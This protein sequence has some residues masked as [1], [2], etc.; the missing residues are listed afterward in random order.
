MSL[1]SLDTWV[2][3]LLPQ[4]ERLIQSNRL[5]A[6]LHAMPTG[7]VILDSQG[8]IVDA[9]GNA[10][11]LLGEPLVAL[12]WIKVIERS[13]SPKE[14]DGHEVSLK[15]GRRVKISL[16]PLDNKMGELIV[17]TDLTE[18]RHLQQKIAHLQRLSALGE[19]IATLAHQIRTPLSA[20]LLYASHLANQKLKVSDKKK[21][22][23][24]LMQRLN[25]LEVQV[26]DLLAFAQDQRL[27]LES[28]CLADVIEMSVEV[29]Q[30]MLKR[31]GIEIQVEMSTLSEVLGHA[32]ALSSVLN[33]L[34]MNAI[35]AKASKIKVNLSSEDKTFVL[36]IED[37]GCGF[38]QKLTEQVV[39]PF[40]TSKSYGTG[41]GL[42]VV[43]K[44]M[45]HHGGEL[46]LSSELEQGCQV[47]LNFPKICGEGDSNEASHSHC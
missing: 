19:M 9:N 36:S 18:T 7:V 10:A 22:Q 41:L 40:Y 15:D 12:P 27:P 21:F 8:L 47:A 46:I 31:S 3:A 16:T 34:L 45:R 32:H 6:L 38:D 1:P 11:L 14:D 35:E 2:D 39:Q 25:D 20:A 24:K 5:K 44:V 43:Q 13:F 4:K 17:L 42:A 30:P 26:N 28:I 29:V 23:S 37:N 33:N